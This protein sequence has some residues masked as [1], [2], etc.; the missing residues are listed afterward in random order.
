MSE[1]AKGRG[2]S[3]P[4]EI[5]FIDDRYF[6]DIKLMNPIKD[7]LQK[8]IATYTAI[9]EVKVI[10]QKP[11]CLLPGNKKGKVLPGF[12]NLD[13]LSEKFMTQLQGQ[14]DQTIHTVLRTTNKLKKCESDF[15]DQ[16]FCRLCYGLKDKITNLLEVGSTVKKIDPETSEI[17]K[18][19]E[20]SDLW[21][22]GYEQEL[23]FGC[24]RV[25]DS[26]EDIEKLFELLPQFMKES[27]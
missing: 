15:E 27:A 12:G 13:F 14:N 7:A 10:P 4:H 23:C 2:L 9:N 20:E 24:K 6:H 5:A 11:L 25:F 17:E 26:A 18:A 16:K 8:E 19:E 1:I 21:T 3:L 22:L